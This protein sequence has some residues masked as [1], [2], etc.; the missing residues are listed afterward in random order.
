MRCGLGE[1][2]P[3]E[4]KATRQNSETCWDKT[5]VVGR[6]AWRFQEHTLEGAFSNG[7]DE[8]FR[9]AVEALEF[10][11]G[12]FSFFSFISYLHPEEGPHG[13]RGSQR[14]SHY[15][16]QHI[17]NRAKRPLRFRG[18]QTPPRL[19]SIKDLSSSQPRGV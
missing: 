10:L 12:V 6:A 19:T 7:V 11:L 17:C 2:L 13:P 1:G 18:G 3:R 14:T 4:R 8:T 15:I 9:G 5:R 16:R